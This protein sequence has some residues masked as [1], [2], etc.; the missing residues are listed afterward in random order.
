MYV[1]K[2]RLITVCSIRHSAGHW[3]NLNPVHLKLQ[4]YG[5]TEI[6][7]LIYYHYCQF[8]QGCGQGHQWYVDKVSA[9]MDHYKCRKMIREL[10]RQWYCGDSG[11]VNEQGLKSPTTHY[12]SFWRQNFPVSHLH[13]YWQPNKNNQETE[14]TNNTMQKVVLVNITTHSEKKL[15]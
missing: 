7:L 2:Y 12:R 15:G 14:H 5:A 13:W 4:W 11:W 9:A 3:S 6:L 1:I 8:E 10:R